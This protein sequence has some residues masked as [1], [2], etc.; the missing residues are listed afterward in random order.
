MLVLILIILKILNRNIAALVKKMNVEV[1]YLE[2]IND[3]EEKIWV[4]LRKVLDDFAIAYNNGTI[5][6]NES[7]PVNTKVTFNKNDV[8][9]NIEN[10]EYI[11]Y[12]NTPITTI[13][14]TVIYVI[15]KFFFIF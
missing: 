4:D 1:V 15:S 12:S 8:I 9:T 14:T 2:K 3:G 7:V 6:K 10:N 13:V 11:S 5:I